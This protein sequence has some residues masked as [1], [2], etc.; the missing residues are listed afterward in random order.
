[1]ACSCFTYPHYF[2]LYNESDI[3]DEFRKYMKMAYE[4]GERKHIKHKSK[5]ATQNAH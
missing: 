2:K 4:I 1:V 5:A 3:D